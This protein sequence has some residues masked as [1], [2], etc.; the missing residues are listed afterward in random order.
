MITCTVLGMSASWEVASATQ[1]F[2]F[3]A[4]KTGTLATQVADHIGGSARGY[5]SGFAL[6]A[7]QETTNVRV[8]D[9]YIYALTL[10][11][12]PPASAR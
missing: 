6:S 4:A 5:R 3:G 10:V 9:S 8:A 11:G 1:I 2:R 7:N 12:R